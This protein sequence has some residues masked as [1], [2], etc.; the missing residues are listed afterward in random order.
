MTPSRILS[1]VPNTGRRLRYSVVASMMLGGSGLSCDSNDG[2][3][4][5]GLSSVSASTREQFLSSYTEL[6]CAYSQSCPETGLGGDHVA[7]GCSAELALAL[8]SS[9]MWNSTSVDYDPGEGQRCL[10]ALA[11]ETCESIGNASGNVDEPCR[12]VFTGAAQVG[13]SCAINEECA[14]DLYCRVTDECPGTCQ[15]LPTLRE[16]CPGWQ[17]APGLNCVDGVCADGSPRGA[18]CN[19]DW[20][21]ADGLACESY[22]GG[23]DT[24]QPSAE[25]YGVRAEG[26]TCKETGHCQASLYCNHRGEIPVCAKQQQEGEECWSSTSPADACAPGTHCNIPSASEA[27]ICVVDGALGSPCD[28]FVLYECGEGEC[29]DGTCQSQIPL[30]EPCSADDACYSGYCESGACAVRPPCIGWE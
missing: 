24:C 6:R 28:P 7:S 23:S 25:I 18:T 8:Q 29:I 22:A 5:R 30:G 17:C 4:H 19:G 27:G 2:S 12:W 15:A 21:C 26:E 1:G 13:D 9:L 10:D 14:R 20:D 16:P 11:A 3:E